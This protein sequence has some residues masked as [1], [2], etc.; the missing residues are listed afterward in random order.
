MGDDLGTPIDGVRNS[1]SPLHLLG[2]GVIES[3]GGWCGIHF[4]GGTG[5]ERFAILPPHQSGSVAS[6]RVVSILLFGADIPFWVRGVGFPSS[7][8]CLS[9]ILEDFP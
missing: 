8:A 3:V 2:G 1:I 7:T 9:R 5:S 4:L 6:S